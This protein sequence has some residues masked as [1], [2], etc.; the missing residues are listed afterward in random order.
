MHTICILIAC[1]SFSYLSLWISPREQLC[2][3]LWICSICLLMTRKVAK[4]G[5]ECGA[6]IVPASWNPSLKA[7]P[8]LESCSCTLP[9]GSPLSYSHFYSVSP[10]RMPLLDIFPKVRPHKQ[11]CTHSHI[12]SHSESTSQSSWSD[13][14]LAV[15]CLAPSTRT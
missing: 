14:I 7:G 6:D 12:H 9:A 3:A 1:F 8:L 5:R 15:Y 13:T 4:E 10:L 11:M 2:P